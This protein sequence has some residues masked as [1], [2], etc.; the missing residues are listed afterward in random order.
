[1][2]RGEKALKTYR[3][4]VKDGEVRISVTGKA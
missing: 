1:V 2:V 3:V 4:T